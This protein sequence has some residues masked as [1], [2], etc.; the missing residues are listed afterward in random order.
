MSTLRADAKPPGWAQQVFLFLQG[1]ITPYFAMVAD[2][3]E[4]QGHRCLRVNLCFGDRLFWRRAGAI[5]YRGTREG[6]PAFVA[7]LIDRERVTDLVLLGEQRFYH[8]VAIA[9]A[10]AR[11]AN[12]TVTDFGYLRPDW[13]TLERDG[14]SGDSRFPRDPEAILDLAAKAPEPQL[15]PRFADNFRRQAIWDIAY[16]LSSS[17]FWFMH[18]GYKSHQVHHPGLVY[19]GTGLHFLRARRNGRKADELIA[20]VRASGRPYYVLPLQ[21]ENDFQLRAYS[22]F[23]DMKTPIH[24]V[25]RSFADHA[26]TDARLLIKIHPLDPGI[27]N[28]RRIV[29]R[30]AERWGVVE[31]VDFLDGGSLA[32]LLEGSQGVVTVNSTVGIWS[33]RAGLPTMTLGAAVY[34]IPGLT[35]QGQLDRFW[36]EAP[37]PDPELW[38]AFVKALVNHI[39]IRGVYYEWEG[40]AA[41][42]SETA[43][44]LIAHDAWLDL[45]DRRVTVESRRAE[46]RAEQR[47]A[48][49]VPELA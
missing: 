6:W 24:T 28:W 22:P 27:R 48:F 5:N 34:D 46:R 2:A 37:R 3:L 14:M 8:K 45:E 11:G 12:V 15:E 35:Y 10:K 38:E 7:D 44:R 26:P 19:L 42:V 40:L 43:R 33:L 29:R 30:S 23:P 47:R 32:L 41:A 39:Q 9:A 18:P 25:I 31:R 36:T 49:N 16:H 4:R 20:E 21:M 13:I 17:F 1:P